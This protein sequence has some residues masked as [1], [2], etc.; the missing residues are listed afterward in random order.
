MSDDP[1]SRIPESLAERGGLAP[2]VAREIARELGVAEAHVTGVGSF[3]HLLARPTARV[4]VCTGLSCRLGG[5]DAVLAAAEASGLPV[6]GVP[7][8]AACDA[9]PAVLRD[10]RVL[11]RVPV[12]A[13]TA[14][15]GRVEA[16]R[17]PGDPEPAPWRGTV[18][19]ERDDP[20][21]LVLN[22]HGAPRDGAPSLARTRELGAA[23]VELEVATRGDHLAR[24]RRPVAGDRIVH[25]HQLGAVRKR[26]LDLDVV[27][28]LGHPV[29]DVV[30]AQH[31][32][33]LVHE[34][35]DRLAVARALDDG[36]ADQRHRLRVVELEAPGLA[37][38]GQERGGRQEQLV[39]LAWG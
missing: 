19:P 4:R 12:A 7:C 31:P 13:V 10:R 35:G 25:G 15:G 38:L 18:G 23:G 28:H 21:S 22:L 36:E 8:L 5:A 16:L 39:L 30:R 34:L 26:G 17:S 32:A 20:E 3:F 11:P 9:P 1:R 27:D 14:A 6:E 2:G 37:P 24:Q 33:A 29:H